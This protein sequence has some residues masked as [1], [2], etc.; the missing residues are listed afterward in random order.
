MKTFPY[1]AKNLDRDV[2]KTAVS[3]LNEVAMRTMAIESPETYYAWCLD[4]Y[5][6]QRKARLELEFQTALL[7]KLQRCD[8]ARAREIVLPVTDQL[9]GPEHVSH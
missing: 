9:E 1:R 8:P 2:A 4:A 6:A 7:Q 3:Q 5:T